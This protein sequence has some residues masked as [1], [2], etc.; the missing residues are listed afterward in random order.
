[1]PVGTLATVPLPVPV[2]FT[3]RVKAWTV[4]VAVTIVAALRLTTQAS[5]PEQPPPLQPVKVEPVAG[6]A[7]RVIMVPTGKLAEQVVPHV[8]P[9]GELVTEP[10]PVP[11]G[12]TVA[13]TR[14]GS[15]ASSTSTQSSLPGP[16]ALIPGV[17]KLS[18]PAF[19]NGEPG[20]LVNVPAAGSYHRAVT[21]PLSRLMSTVTVR[22]ELPGVAVGM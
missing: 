10:L 9:A 14:G 4:K 8:I 20:M 7:V 16:S 6:V 3:V 18:K 12:I 2:L 15:A 13:L 19:A 1:M 17:V 21:G 22:D 5:V 11:A